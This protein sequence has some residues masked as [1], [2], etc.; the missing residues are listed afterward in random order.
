MDIQVYGSSSFFHET[1]LFFYESLKT[2]AESGKFILG[3]RRFF[4][5]RDIALIS[6][7]TLCPIE[8][9]T[10][11]FGQIESCCCAT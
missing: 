10:K 3:A 8:K 2:Q 6:T 7:L 11:I 1:H 9:A 4:F 5:E